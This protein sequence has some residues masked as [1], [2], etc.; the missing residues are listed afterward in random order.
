[1]EK[2]M[3]AEEKRVRRVY[4]KENPPVIVPDEVEIDDE[5]DLS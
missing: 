5:D 4:R 2:R 1:M 3:K